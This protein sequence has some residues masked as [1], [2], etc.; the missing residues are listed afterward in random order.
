MSDNEINLHGEMF[1]GVPDKLKDLKQRDP[2]DKYF[3][4]KRFLLTKANNQNEVWVY[5]VRRR[6]D[7]KIVAVK[8]VTVRTDPNH[9]NF[10]EEGT[11][12]NEVKILSKLNKFKETLTIFDV[13]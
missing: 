2:E 4:S 9:R 3:F 7:N 5:R 6:Y 1:K 13:F 12:L 8:V 11:W 10:R